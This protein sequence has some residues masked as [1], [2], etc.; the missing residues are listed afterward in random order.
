MCHSLDYKY[1]DSLVGLA[2]GDTLGATL[3]FSSPGSFE[4]IDDITGGGPIRLESGEW[5][6]DTSR[7]LRLGKS[8]IEREGLASARP[9]GEL[10]QGWAQESA[11]EYRRTQPSPT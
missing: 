10:C 2:V 3:E 6:D 7:A 1:T 11:A 5:T 8:L 4:S 9:D